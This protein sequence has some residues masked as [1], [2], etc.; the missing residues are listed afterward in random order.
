LIFKNRI[1]RIDRIVFG[2]RIKNSNTLAFNGLIFVFVL[3]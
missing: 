3:S 2:G 1:D